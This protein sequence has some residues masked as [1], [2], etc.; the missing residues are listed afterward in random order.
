[1][2]GLIIV[3]VCRIS[4]YIK[5][6][7]FFLS[8]YLYTIKLVKISQQCLKEEMPSYDST[9]CF[10]SCLSCIHYFIKFILVFVSRCIIMVRLR[11]FTIFLCRLRVLCCGCR[12]SRPPDGLLLTE[13]WSVFYS[14]GGHRQSRVLLLHTPPSQDAHLHQQEV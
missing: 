5:I 14:L 6:K 8:I 12:P 13:P 1:M 9:I 11:L 7:Y 4:A 3:Y 10:V 2:L